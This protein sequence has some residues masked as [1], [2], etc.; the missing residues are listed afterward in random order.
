MD[1]FVEYAATKR[2]LAGALRQ[3]VA[4]GGDPYLQSRAK[5]VDA[6]G[7]LLE[8]AGRAGSIR[9]DLD[10]EDVMP[11]V[12]GIRTL[13]DDPGWER[14]ARTLLGLVME[15]SG[16]EP[17]RPGVDWILLKEATADRVLVMPGEARDDGQAHTRPPPQRK[18]AAKSRVRASWSAA[19]PSGR[20]ASKRHDRSAWPVVAAAASVRAGWRTRRLTPRTA[21]RSPPSSQQAW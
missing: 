10:P 16:I 2:G 8:A 7:R 3:M 15:G 20:A 19:N 12:A 17:E 4:S 18:P 6:L 1:L 5:I 21:T 11:A 9:A 14:R 13:P